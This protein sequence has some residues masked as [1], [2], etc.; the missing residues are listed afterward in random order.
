MVG[1]RL[2]PA[3]RMLYPSKSSLRKKFK[4]GRGQ[5]QTAWVGFANSARLP[6]HAELRALLAV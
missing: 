4:S 5:L 3:I 2:C 6:H 1:E